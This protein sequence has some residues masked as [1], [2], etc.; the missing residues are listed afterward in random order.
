MKAT[1]M[2][3]VQRIGRWIRGSSSVRVFAFAFASVV[4]L[5]SGCCRPPEPDHPRVIDYDP[6][7][8]D[9]IKTRLDQAEAKKLWTA[10]DAVAFR[11][12]LAYLSP[13]NRMASALRLSALI[14]SRAVL[15]DRTPSKKPPRRRCPCTPG[16]C[17]GVA[18]PPPP[19]PPPAMTVPPVAA[20]PATKA[21]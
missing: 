17:D 4:P 9:L 21:K 3:F 5:L 15:F 12:S 2:H 11:R 8:A 1:L 18:M 14:N 13:E 16:Y 7:Q 10:E 20:P 19:A 6:R